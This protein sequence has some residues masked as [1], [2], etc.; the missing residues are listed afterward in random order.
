MSKYFD[1]K[2]FKKYLQFIQQKKYF[3]AWM[4]RRNNR[5]FSLI[6]TRFIYYNSSIV[7]F[8]AKGFEWAARGS[9][10]GYISNLN[11]NRGFQILF[12]MFCICTG[13][14]LV[15]VLLPTLYIA[16]MIHVARVVYKDRKDVEDRLFI[17]ILKGKMG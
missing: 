5:Y 1:R 13:L 11:L 10:K 6:D 15:I 4:F 2:E 9:H 12:A 17:G 3:G 14:F 16:K 8:L 7:K